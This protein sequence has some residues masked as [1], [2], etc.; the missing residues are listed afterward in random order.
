[1]EHIQAENTH[2]TQI[3]RQFTLVAHSSQ[4]L[5]GVGVHGRLSH[6]GQSI[7][8]MNQEVVCLFFMNRRKKEAS[9]CVSTRIIS[10][11]F[12]SLNLRQTYRL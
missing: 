7:Q 11:E 3:A 9:N 8:L 6:D 5:I 1:M 12:K 4:R 10:Q 2:H